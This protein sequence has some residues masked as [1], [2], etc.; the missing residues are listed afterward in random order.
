MLL[1]GLSHSVHVQAS[2]LFCR[3]VRVSYRPSPQ[4]LSIGPSVL[5]DTRGRTSQ[6]AGET[7]F[8]GF[9]LLGP[10]WDLRVTGLL[11]LYSFSGGKIAHHQAQATRRLTHPIQV[12]YLVPRAMQQPE[13]RRGRKEE[14]EL[15][16]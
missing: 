10:P 14:R 13:G 2:Y 5:L 12:S 6:K 9:L 3:A 8:Q 16:Q 4:R 1:C 7:K 11:I 15:R